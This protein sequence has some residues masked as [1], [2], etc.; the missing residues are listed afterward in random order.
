[1]E[2]AKPQ[3]VAESK[4]SKTYA[5]SCLQPSTKPNSCCEMTY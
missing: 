5:A 2:Y 1:M 3:V 4:E